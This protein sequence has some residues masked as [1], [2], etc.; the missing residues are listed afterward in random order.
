MFPPAPPVPITPPLADPE[1]PPIP[2][3]AFIVDELLNQEVPPVVAVPELVP[4]PPVPTVKLYVCP[5]VSEI[6]DL[7]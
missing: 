6:V 5:G 4:G 7:L 1:S 2:P 3:L